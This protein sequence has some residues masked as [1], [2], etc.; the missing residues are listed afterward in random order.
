MAFG[1]LVASPFLLLF[2][3]WPPLP[4]FEV[5]TSLATGRPVCSSASNLFL[6]P[7]ARP[8]ISSPSLDETFLD[9]SL[10]ALAFSFPLY[11]VEGITSSGFA[12]FFLTLSGFGPFR[13][14]F[15]L[16]R[17]SAISLGGSSAKSEAVGWRACSSLYAGRMH[18]PN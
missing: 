3:L 17:G 16:C 6:L 13:P 14:F 8:R 7:L 10:A 2:L 9:L 12:F 18:Q 11:L 15:F 1:R 4:S 5:C